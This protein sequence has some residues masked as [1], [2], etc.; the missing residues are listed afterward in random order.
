MEID[1]STTR[2]EV[3]G[4]DENTGVSTRVGMEKWGDVRDIFTPFMG[5]WVDIAEDTA[6]DCLDRHR[7]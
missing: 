5:P 2:Q 7:Q 1:I 4:K 3:K 6:G